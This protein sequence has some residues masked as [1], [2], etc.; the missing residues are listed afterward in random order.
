M[1]GS[2]V[3]L[4]M[5][6]FLFE[7]ILCSYDPL[8][9]LKCSLHAAVYPDNA[10][11]DGVSNAKMLVPNSSRDITW[12]N[13]ATWC[14]KMSQAPQGETWMVCRGYYMPDSTILRSILFL[15]QRPCNSTLTNS[16]DNNELHTQLWWLQMVMEMFIFLFMVSSISL[17]FTVV[18]V[19]Y[20]N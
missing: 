20:S 7:I 5:F 11:S 17:I 4:V 6:R 8:I 13:H 16:T 2:P 14:R 3:L 12:K 19:D 15:S 1:V 18:A 10:I 9:T